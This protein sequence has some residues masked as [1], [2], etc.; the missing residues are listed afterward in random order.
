MSIVAHSLGGNIALRYAG[1]YP[2]NVHRLVAIE[3]LGPAPRSVS[4]D[5]NASRSPS[6]CAPG[7]IR[8]RAYS[9]RQP[10]RYKTFDDALARMQE[11]NKHL[12]PD[13]VR[14]LTQHAVNR[15]RT[16]PT[17][18]SSIITSRSGRPMT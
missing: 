8:P 7:S 9:G 4:G 16:A 15:T 11:A 3:G 14:H 17:A 2:E 12:R 1:I 10:R 5:A 13:Q 18:G 6:A